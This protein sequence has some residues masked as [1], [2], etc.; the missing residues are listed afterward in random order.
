[1]SVIPPIT[2]NTFDVSKI[3]FSELKKLDNGSYASYLNAANGP[4]RKLRVQGPQLPVPYKANDYQGNANYSVSQSFRDEA[5]NAK[6]KAFRKMLD[7]IDAFVLNEVTKNAGKWLGIEGASKDM[8]KLFFTPSIHFAKDKVTKKVRT[9]L[10]PTF[11]AKLKQKNGAFD[12]EMFNKDLQRIKNS[13]GTFTSP[14][15]I[16]Q[17]G[18]EFTG[19]FECTGIWIV[20]KK[21][22]ITW[23][24]HSAW[25][26]VSAGLAS[27]GPAFVSD[28]GNTLVVASEGLSAE[29]EAG[30]LA[31]VAP[32]DED[33]EDA[34]ED[35]EVAEEEAEEEAPVE[36]EEAVVAPPPLPVKVAPVVVTP[37]PAATTTAAPAAPKKVPK[38]TTT[39]A[40]R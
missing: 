27:S 35:E 4:D 14:L 30:V 12:A 29:D 38:K 33:A 26:N 9:D 40:S 16:L 1:M 36:E 21:F 8:V 37:T 18:T 19:I 2:P 11:Q 32:E 20:D 15:E 6:V 22:G 24:L 28:D 13:D 5:T 23:K 17:Q 31:A 7:S 25:M 39:A 10:P 3:T 34:A